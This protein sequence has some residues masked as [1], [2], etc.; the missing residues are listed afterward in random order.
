MGGRE[1]AILNELDP[2]RVLGIRKKAGPAEIDSAYSSLYNLYERRAY[3]G[4]DNAIALLQRLNDAYDE[5][6]GAAPVS[7]SRPGAGRQGAARTSRGATSKA[8]KA[9]AILKIEPGATLE[10][11]ED[12]YDYLFTRYE[13]RALG[14]D[15]AATAYLERLNSAYDT[16]VGRSAVDDDDEY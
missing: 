15:E 10:E 12:A 7:N 6:Q 1:R 8:D 13:K 16:L 14:G 3:S 11:I 5:I 4:D 2:N 9:Y